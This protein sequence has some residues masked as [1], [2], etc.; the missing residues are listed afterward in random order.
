MP[1]S[2]L[3]LQ[4]L[5]NHIAFVIDSSGSM[6]YI[7]RDTEIVFDNEISHLKARSQELNQE[8]RISVY[9]F[10]GN[11]EC[12]VSDM[13]VMRMPSLKNQLVSTGSTA[14][15]DATSKAIQDMKLLPETYGD[16]A[17]LAYVLTDG[18]E[19]AS[20]LVS[21]ATFKFLLQ[22]LRDNWTVACLVPNAYC[23]HEAKQ[24]GFP[25]AS[26]AT[27]TT[28]KKG[29]VEVGKTTRTAMDNYMMGR[30]SGIRSTNAFFTDLSNVSKTTITR[31][32]EE[33]KTTDYHFLNVH[34]DSVIKPFVESWLKSYRIGS[35]YYE[36]VK[37]E[38]IQSSKQIAIKDKKNGRVYSGH[39]ARSLLNLPNKL[40]RVRP[41]DHGNWTI[42]VQ[43][44]S[45]NRKLP[46]G[47]SVIVM[48]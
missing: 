6:Q 23:I 29:V 30:A 45:I 8:T 15:L 11:V 14:L 19:N 16:H 38:D 2:K 32:L 35:A 37:P 10:N 21:K 20:M 34:K 17:F 22:E 13:D 47:T 9:A 39:N 36:L 27:W 28:D 4:H 26:I 7:M 18:E 24:F 44:T 5:I 25:A 40:Q 1:I 48:I 42:Y 31:T 33:L 12:L 3:K 43:S 46:A 41:G